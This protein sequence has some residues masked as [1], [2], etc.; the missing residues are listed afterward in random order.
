MST[1][2]KMPKEEYVPSPEEISRMTAKIR[3]GWTP[4]VRA[5]RRRMA[6]VYQQLLLSGNNRSAA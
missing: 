6:R 4:Q 1:T 2:M 3:K 5:T